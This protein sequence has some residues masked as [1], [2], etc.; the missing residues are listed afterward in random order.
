MRM[1]RT[2]TS[3][4]P[5]KFSTS[6]MPRKIWDRRKIALLS[7]NDRIRPWIKERHAELNDGKIDAIIA[8]PRIYS[9]PDLGGKEMHRVSG[10][11]LLAEA[12][13]RVQGPGI[14]RLLR[15]GRSRLQGDDRSRSQTIGHALDPHQ[16]QC[17]HCAAMWETKRAGRRILR[18]T[19]SKKMRLQIS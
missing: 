6:F 14:L 5:F 18:A 4:K 12:V 7:R 1:T 15:N 11:E 2:N 17:Q 10:N 13:S 16:L 8:K 19:G 9:P 3:P